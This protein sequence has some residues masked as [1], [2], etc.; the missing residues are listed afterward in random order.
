[1][2]HEILQS[3]LQRVEECGCKQGCP[4][5]VGPDRYNKDLTVKFLKRVKEK[6]ISIAE[7]E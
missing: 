2:K 1:M 7:A 4:S 3:S 5:C 6:S